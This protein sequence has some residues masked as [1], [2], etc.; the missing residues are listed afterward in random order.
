MRSLSVRPLHRPT[1]RSV[2]AASP[3]PG[4]LLGV[5]RRPATLAPVDTQG[6]RRT[7]LAIAVAV[8][9]A[10]GYLA[11]EITGDV[12]RYRIDQERAAIERLDEELRTVDAKIDETRRLAPL[13]DGAV[14]LLITP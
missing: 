11:L 9:L 8:I 13:G 4:L 12:L 1:R 14:D 2:V 6:S 7:F 3:R 10:G 5:P